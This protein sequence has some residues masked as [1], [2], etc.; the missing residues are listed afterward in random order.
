MLLPYVLFVF[1]NVGSYLLSLRAGSHVI[2]LSDFAYYVYGQEP[3][4]AVHLA[5]WYVLLVCHQHDVC[6]NSVGSVYVGGYG[7]LTESG[8]CVFCKLCPVCFL[9][10]GNGP[11]VLL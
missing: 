8:L 10:V 1:L 6:E 3:A 2:S 4:V 9:V 5:L 11:S 7:G